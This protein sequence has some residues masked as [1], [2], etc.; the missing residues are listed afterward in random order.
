MKNNSAGTKNLSGGAKGTLPRSEKGAVTAAPVVKGE[1]KIVADSISVW[2]GIIVTSHW[3]LFDPLVVDG[4]DFYFGE[5]ELGHIHLNG[6]IHIATNPSMGGSL[7]KAGLAKPL[8]YIQGWVEENI[9][10]IGP[11]AAVH[12]FK[13][14]YTRLSKGLSV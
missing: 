5:E 4:I 14:N 2:P 6:D 13:Q 12:L 9:Y 11:E 10:K 8:P 7:V 3:D 1:L